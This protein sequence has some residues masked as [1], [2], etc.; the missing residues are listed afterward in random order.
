M[1]ETT[2][3]AMAMAM[4]TQIWR[5]AAERMVIPALLPVFGGHRPALPRSPYGPD[6][7][8]A[9]GRCLENATARA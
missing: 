1:T 7:A 9:V 5:V 3:M 2:A 6:F 8:I 4:A